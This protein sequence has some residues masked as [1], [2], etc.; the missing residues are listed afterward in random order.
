MYQNYFQKIFYDL[1]FPI[2]TVMKI[3]EDIIS[4]FLGNDE[5]IVD[6]FDDEDSALLV[7]EKDRGNDL[8][9]EQAIIKCQMTHGR[10]RT[11]TTR[12]CISKFGKD[13]TKR[14]QSRLAMRK[15]RG[16]CAVKDMEHE[17][18]NLVTKVMDL[19]EKKY[20]DNS[21]L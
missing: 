8:A 7:Q 3:I 2:N 10:L 21:A 9:C 13:T 17:L 15:K 20:F 12:L 1:A 19:K 4:T 11:T 18:V 5:Y 6:T 14:A 16:N